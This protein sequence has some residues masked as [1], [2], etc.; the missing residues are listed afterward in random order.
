[1]RTFASFRAVRLHVLVSALA[2]ATHMPA[3]ALTAPNVVV[4]DANL[5]T[6]GQPSAAELANLRAERFDAVI[7]LAPA[8]V[9]DAVKEEPGIVGNQGIEFVHIPIPFSTP[10]E[11]HFE[12]VS[13]ALQRLQGK[14][15]LVHC[16]VNL[17]ASTMVFLFRVLQRKESPAAAY[18]AVTRVWS[19][20]GPWRTMA[21]GLLAKRGISFELY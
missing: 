6:S 4:V 5:V 13:S 15:V 14:K 11:S 7:Y 9:S 3:R 21:Q 2:L 10:S 17:R 16:Q 1:M 8:T 18:D 12:A 20:Q 19:P